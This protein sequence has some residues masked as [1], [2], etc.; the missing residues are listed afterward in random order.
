MIWGPSSFI[1][2]GTET[3]YMKVTETQI[4]EEIYNLPL[5]NDVVSDTNWTKSKVAA[6]VSEG[7]VKDIISLGGYLIKGTGVKYRVPNTFSV[8]ENKRKL[9][10]RQLPHADAASNEFLSILLFLGE[11]GSSSTL[12]RRTPV[13]S[14]YINLPGA[15]RDRDCKIADDGVREA[16]L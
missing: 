3:R 5:P 1:N 7:K 13:K 10:K 12:F 8:L 11:N 6:R 4:A 15:I 14:S 2:G 16:L 9:I